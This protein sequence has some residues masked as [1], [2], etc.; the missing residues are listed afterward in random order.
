MLKTP[1]SAALSALVLAATAALGQPGGAL[2]QPIGNFDVFID[3]AQDGG[4]RVYQS[5]A[6][7]A[8][9]I[10][11]GGLP[12]A[13][14]VHVRSRG[15][16]AVPVDRLVAQGSSFRL[17]LGDPLARLGSFEIEGAVVV[18]QVG[19][20]EVRLQP[21]PPLV[22]ERTIDE[23]FDHSPEYR[24][25][26]DAYEPDAELIGQLRSVSGSYRVRIV[27]GSWCAVCNRY[28]PRGLK[29]QEALGKSAFQFEYYGLPVEGAWEHPQ[30]KILEVKSLPTAVVF[31]G[32]DV[33]GRF[34]GGEEWESP[35][36]ML[37][38]AVSA[39]Q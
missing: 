28:L 25:T 10:V 3:G 19:R 31:R 29:V 23:L 4:A 11:S 33:V 39:A 21:S 27:F 6:A 24:A 34:A 14:L 15:V 30:V 2:F 16:E 8:V 5:S 32:D 36:K 26:A 20:Q 22:G 38:E 13:L 18:I 12:S 37:W 7:P 17:L 9:L 35:E 1:A